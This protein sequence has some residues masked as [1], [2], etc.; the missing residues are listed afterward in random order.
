MGSTYD[1]EA[2][3]WVGTSE[4]DLSGPIWPNRSQLIRD[5][6][7]GKADVF[8]LVEVEAE[9]R[10]F[11]DRHICESFRGSELGDLVK[12]RS[13]IYQICRVQAHV[14]VYPRCGAAVRRDSGVSPEP[15]RAI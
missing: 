8:E 13:Y 4:P 2:D 14:V 9:T 5:L 7:T 3:R 6:R 15:Q 10:Y 11:S 12:Y 1:R